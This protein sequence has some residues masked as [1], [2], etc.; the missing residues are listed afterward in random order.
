MIDM[1]TSPVTPS[2]NDTPTTPEIEAVFGDGPPI[3]VRAAPAASIVAEWRRLGAFLRRPS[4][5][6]GEQSASPFTV[7]ARIYALDMGIMFALI[8]LAGAVIA[9]GVEL[10][11]TALAGMEFTLSI[12]L[13]VI[14]V[15]P[16]MEE[17]VFRSW[18]GGKPG[19]IIALLSFGGGVAVF[20]SLGTD[21]S[22]VGAL[23]LITGIAGAIAALVI[24]RNRPAMG[25]FAR[26]FP[27]FFWLST[28]AFALIHLANFDEGALVM[29][30]PL[31]LPQ[32]VL[33]GLLGYVRVRIG[34]W[35]AI[36]LHAAHNA[37]AFGIAALAMGLE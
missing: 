18:L 3:E 23:F 35:A 2:A 26:A 27:A 30:L 36:L 25:W 31:V 9:M 24:F 14:L 22:L 33:G 15:A 16:V 7:L 4:L 5:D 34:L 32:F 12:V 6:V 21:G 17:L 13:L 10:P 19:P 28:L 29:L 1:T 37:T 11:E 20:G 8:L